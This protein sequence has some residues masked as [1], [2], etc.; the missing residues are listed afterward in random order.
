MSEVVLDDVKK[1]AIVDFC[2]EMSASMTRRTAEGEFQREAVTH[3]AKE[4]EL[5]KKILR[6]MAKV[7]HD[8]KFA[9]VTAENQEFESAYTEVFGIQE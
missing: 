5:D 2:Q 8:S 9:T 1:K 7:F 4:Y 6:K 3:I